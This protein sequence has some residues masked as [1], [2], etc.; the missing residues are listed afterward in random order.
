VANGYI[1]ANYLIYFTHA[2]ILDGERLYGR[3]LGTPVPVRLAVGRA[4]RDHRR[5]RLLASEE[6]FDPAADRWSTCHGGEQCRR[7]AVL[8]PALAPGA[9]AIHRD[10]LET[11]WELPHRP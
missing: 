7:A 5:G 1:Q 6:A 8:R 4:L 11:V 2:R 9:R 3:Y 10:P